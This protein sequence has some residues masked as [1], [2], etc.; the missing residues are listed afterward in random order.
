MPLSTNLLS[1]GVIPAAAVD[2]DKVSSA[3]VTQ[4]GLCMTAQGI[5]YIAPYDSTPFITQ[6]ILGANLGNPAYYGYD[7]VVGMAK[8]FN[9]YIYLV[10][11]GL[12][13]KPAP[14]TPPISISALAPPAI[15][16]IIQAEMKTSIALTKPV[17]PAGVP[18]GSEQ[19]FY[20]ACATYIYNIYAAP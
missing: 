14:I 16:S 4:F 7:V 15:S 8:A 20:T 10:A 19:P 1:I 5:G 17:A 11:A 13:V 9:A 12:I 18:T 3:M 6:S 2:F